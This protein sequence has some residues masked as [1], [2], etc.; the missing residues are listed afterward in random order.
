MAK[1]ISFGGYSKFYNYLLLFILSKIIYDFVFGLELKNS[2]FEKAKFISTYLQEKLSNH[3]LM[4]DI[5][6]YIGIFFLSFTTFKIQN[7]LNK[8]KIVQPSNKKEIERHSSFVELIHNE[9][10]DNLSENYSTIEVIAIIILWVIEE[11]LMKIYYKFGLEDL[12]FWTLELLIISLISSKMFHTQI[13]RH[14]KLAIIFSSIFCTLLKII[15]LILNYKSSENTEKTKNGLQNEFL[16]PIGIISFLFIAFLRS[17]VN[18]KIK[19]FMDLK[20]ISHSKLLMTYGLI[21]LSITSIFCLITTF[22]KCYEG[23]IDTQK[24]N[25]CKVTENDQTYYYDSFSIYFKLLFGNNTIN[26]PI[27]NTKNKVEEIVI[28][29]IEVPIG[30]ISNFFAV[31]LYVLIIKILTPVHIICSYSLYYLILQISLLINN[32]CFS[33]YY[34]IGTYENTTK[35]GTKFIF[36]TVA[37]GLSFLIILVYL[38][39]IELNFC[40]LDYNLKKHIA[41]R[42]T[43]DSI[44]N[45]LN[46]DDD[47]DEEDENNLERQNNEELNELK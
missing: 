47:E 25:I 39:L 37:D 21:G 10:E 22:I 2:N 13:H 8:K 20:Y 36:D 28:E 19:D 29:F 42:G 26:N 7:C 18:C 23:K 1:F 24:L 4:H 33:G 16:I 9:V 6:C 43:E 35:K 27:N 34:F 15:A 32:R 5:F 17:Y 11:Q 45:I 12:D 30:I 38:E 46:K 14:Q 41:R 31:Y 3:S 44:N 40:G